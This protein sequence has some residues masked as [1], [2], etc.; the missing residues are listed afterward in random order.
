M[1]VSRV[2]PPCIKS[3]FYVPIRINFNKGFG[4]SRSR[5]L[6][7]NRKGVSPSQKRARVCVLSLHHEKE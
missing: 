7:G 1:H 6:E 4:S 2:N 5:A 3:V